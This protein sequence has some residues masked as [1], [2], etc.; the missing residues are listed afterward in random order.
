MVIAELLK[1]SRERLAALSD[2]AALDVELLL[3][4]CLG[5]DRSYLRAW[6]DK[7]VDDT[8]LAQFDAL[9]ARRLA[10]EPIAYLIGER[11]FWTLDLKVSPATLIPRPETELLVETVLSLLRDKVQARVLDLGTGTG[12]IALAL[13][14][15]K[16]AWQVQA[17]DVQPEAVVLAEQNRAQCGLANVTVI[18]SNWFDAIAPQAFDVIV[19]NPPYIDAADP[20]LDQGDVRF[21]PK[22]A[23]VA[24]K[25]GMADIELITSQSL[26]FLAPGAYLL[27]EHG[28]QQGEQVR[29][30]LQVA[31]FHQVQTLPDLAG[32]DRVTLGQAPE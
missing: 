6:S 30:C 7:S 26:A 11:G 23:L 21:E 5:K 14:S 22:S 2:S 17:C 8:T 29:A 16:P 18:E 19:S 4:H 10:G 13:A 31:G 3:C 25:Q 28:Y 20:H 9:F 32:L 24:D 1:A 27:F 12:A 15:E